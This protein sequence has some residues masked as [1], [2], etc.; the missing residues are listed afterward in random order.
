M[1]QVGGVREPE[2][3]AER[4]A[5]G[6]A[7]RDSSGD[8]PGNPGRSQTAAAGRRRVAPR[9]RRNRRS[10]RRPARRLLPI[11]ARHESN[12]GRALFEPRDATSSSSLPPRPTP[13]ILSLL[14]A[15]TAPSNPSSGRR[16]IA[17]SSLTVSS[18]P[19]MPNR[20]A[21]PTP[22]KNASRRSA[23][24]SPK[25]SRAYSCSAATSMNAIRCTASHRWPSCSYPKI[26]V[27][28]STA[29][30]SRRPPSSPGK[31]QSATGRSPFWAQVSRAP[32]NRC[33]TRS[34]APT[35]GT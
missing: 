26:R 23:G 7:W 31:I 24:A 19:G 30:H 35:F 14:S 15:S 18:S 34:T 5:V 29:T 3:L 1:L 4:N 28:A 12:A 9:A 13:P 20:I 10:L 17:A 8:E 32:R 11:A 21:R 25:P 27:P 6:R 2:R 33:T 16:A 22:I